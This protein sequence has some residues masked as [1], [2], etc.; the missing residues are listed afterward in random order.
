MQNKILKLSIIC[1]AAIL[2]TGCVHD[3]YKQVNIMRMNNYYS[4]MFSERLVNFHVSVIQDR[5]NLV[6]ILP[7]RIFNGGSANFTALAPRTLS[8]VGNLLK[9]Y[10]M[11]VVKVTGVIPDNAY[12]EKTLALA[13]ERAHQVMKY[14]LS[15]GVKISLAYAVGQLRSEIKDEN[16][17]QEY[18]AVSF[19]KL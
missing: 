7:S 8:E 15:Q 17:S 12:G 1:I 6:V 18:V 19:H 5:E 14:F 10:E 9:C 3:Y 4:Q 2:L 13:G 11:E 16:L